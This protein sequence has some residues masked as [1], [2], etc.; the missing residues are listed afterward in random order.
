MARAAVVVAWLG[1]GQRRPSLVVEPN[2]QRKAVPKTQGCATLARSASLAAALCLRVRRS[3]RLAR[4]LE[5]HGVP[6]PGVRL[7]L[8][9][10]DQAA[11]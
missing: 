7:Q 3:A 4:R 5:A 11:G 9:V 6:S 1:S 2:S 8:E 10:L